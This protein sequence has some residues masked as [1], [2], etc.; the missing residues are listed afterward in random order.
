MSGISITKFL[1]V[2][3]ATFALVA[4]TTF[5]ARLPTVSA[6]TMDVGMNLSYFPAPA[7]TPES[8]PNAVLLNQRYNPFDSVEHR[9]LSAYTNWKN[10][11]P[12]RVEFKREIA[13]FH[14]LRFMD[15]V[16]INNNPRQVNW[17]DRTD[18]RKV[19]QR[20]QFVG[21]APPTQANP[22]IR[23]D[24]SVLQ[25]GG[26]RQI[27]WEWMIRLCN[28]NHS[29]MWVCIPTGATPAYCEEL[30]K[31]IR[32]NL[33]PGLKVYVE[34]SNETWND[35]FWQN[36]YAV[37]EIWKKFGAN[38]WA[39]PFKTFFRNTNGAPPTEVG[40]ILQAR[41]SP[42]AGRIPRLLCLQSLC[43]I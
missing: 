36:Q 7:Y 1:M 31:L 34:W 6:Q 29:H 41:S 22:E 42:D 8:T 11:D 25:G 28:I 9:R 26:G 30:A 19:G 20:S 4:W 33:D 23:P 21:F 12:F 38:R 39:R 40:R 14:V 3:C 32:D 17:S 37:T 16:S 24:L 15:W 35:Q 10:A 18:W 2:N 43:F 13:P 5:Y 27:A